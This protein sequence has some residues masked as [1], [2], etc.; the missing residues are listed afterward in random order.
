MDAAWEPMTPERG[1]ARLLAHCVA[2]ERLDN[3]RPS[4][5]D[6]LQ[7]LLGGELAG[8]L[9]RALV[10]DHRGRSRELVG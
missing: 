4:A 3:V 8:F 9:L 7:H 10:R 6:R 5:R 2:L 1:P